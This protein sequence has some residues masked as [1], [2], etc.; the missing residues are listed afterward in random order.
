LIEKEALNKLKSVEYIN[1]LKYGIAGIVRIVIEQM[2]KEEE[3]LIEEQR[4][5]D[6]RAKDIFELELGTRSYSG[7]LRYGVRTIGDVEKLTIKQI[8]NIPRVGKQSVKE[9]VN[10]MQKFGITLK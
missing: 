6:I 10:A 7:L 2:R 4:M 1:Y 3:Q 5:A 9:I 8:M